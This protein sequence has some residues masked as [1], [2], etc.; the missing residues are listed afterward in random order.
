VRFAF[1]APRL[2]AAIAG[3]HP[4]D[5]DR[6]RSDPPYPIMELLEQLLGLVV[7]QLA[8]TVFDPLVELLLGQ[9]SDAGRRV[10]ASNSSAA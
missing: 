5:Y 2:D 1:E 3:H 4:R 6:F 7:V 9:M 8:P 10:A